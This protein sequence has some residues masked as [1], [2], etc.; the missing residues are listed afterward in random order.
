MYF[1]FFLYIMIINIELK[2]FFINHNIKT[3][4][5]VYKE[6]Y[7]NKNVTG[8]GDF[9]RGCYF[10][11]D[12]CKIYNLQYNIIVLHP[13]Y[14]F[15]LNTNY[16]NKDIT[17]SISFFDFTNFNENIHLT[18]N[19]DCR[20]LNNELLSYIKKLPIIE[21]NVYLYNTVFPIQPI[22]EENKTTVFKLILPN[23]R[24]NVYIEDIL[25]QLKLQKYV[26]KAIH[27]RYGDNYMIQKNGMKLF[28][29]DV[30][31]KLL[32]QI[33][34][35]INPKDN[36]IMLSDCPFI[37][38]YILERIP[39][40]KCVFKEITH[41]GEGVLLTDNSIKDTLLDFYLLSYSNAIYS[42]SNYQHGSSFSKWCAITYNIPFTPYRI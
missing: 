19:N 1:I 33:Q 42:F 32:S 26:Y 37:K 12:F 10:L 21:N 41:L 20:E 11:L 18:F 31:Q 17:E 6:K 3:I 13:I 39:N 24:M 8:F 25:N 5:N 34:N 30:I 22:S 16:I 40:T 2:N 36:Y 28:K 15:L 29:K 9:I 23:Y 35:I 14:R 4:N 27:I 7:T 38:K